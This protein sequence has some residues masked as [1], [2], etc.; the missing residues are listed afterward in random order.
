M[1]QHHQQLQAA[2]ASTHQGLHHHHCWAAAPHQMPFKGGARQ[3][4]RQTGTKCDVDDWSLAADM[5]SHQPYQQRATCCCGVGNDC[6]STSYVTTVCPCMLNNL[7][8][9]VMGSDK[10]NTDNARIVNRDSAQMQDMQC[11]SMHLA[12]CALHKSRLIAPFW[13]AHMSLPDEER[14]KSTAN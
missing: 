12:M 7:P 14:H 10:L 2:A 13:S 3:L 1:S 5:L 6:T 9:I 11:A 4:L 8:T